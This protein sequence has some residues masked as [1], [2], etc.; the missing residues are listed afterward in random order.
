MGILWRKIEGDNGHKIEFILY[1]Y[2]PI[3]YLEI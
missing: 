2:I 3:T 1:I